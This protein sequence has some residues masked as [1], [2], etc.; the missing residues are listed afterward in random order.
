M[1]DDAGPTD[2]ASTK[3]CLAELA[4]ALGPP[5]RPEGIPRDE[6]DRAGFRDRLWW[7]LLMLQMGGLDVELACLSILN[8]LSA[9]GREDLKPSARWG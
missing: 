3:D 6:L 2:F 8:E 4:G 7:G 1:T 5:P 9:G